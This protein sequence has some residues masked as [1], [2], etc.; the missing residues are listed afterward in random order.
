MQRLNKF[1]GNVA[2]EETDITKKFILV[3]IAIVMMMFVASM[4]FKIELMKVQVQTLIY[5]S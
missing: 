3:C 1:F 2:V 5:L 4:W